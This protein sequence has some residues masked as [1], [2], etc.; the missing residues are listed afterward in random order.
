VN[1]PP[2]DT[3]GERSPIASTVPG[4]NETLSDES[5]PAASPEPTP[6]ETPCDARQKR[7]LSKA[8]YRA[9]CSADNA[10][11]EAER[12]RVREWRR[13]HPDK[14][15]AQKRAARS[16]NYHR[17]FGAIDSEGQGY[18]GADIVYDGVRYPCS[19]LARAYPRRFD[20]DFP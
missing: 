4:P 20:A 12:Q 3:G 5:E 10:F 1:T 9:R 14:A 13:K 6:A 2:D 8:A 11:R 17:A 16:A 18:P 7:L 19:P 15:R